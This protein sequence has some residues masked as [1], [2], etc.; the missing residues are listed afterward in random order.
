MRF[1]ISYGE[2]EPL[3]EQY[4]ERTY[5]FYTNEDPEAY[6]IT[7]EEARREVGDWHRK[8][9]EEWDIKKEEE[10]FIGPIVKIEEL[11]YQ[12]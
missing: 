2:G 10:Y 5:E 11:L 4:W 12:I 6:G 3:I 9:A 1:M 7:W 8:K